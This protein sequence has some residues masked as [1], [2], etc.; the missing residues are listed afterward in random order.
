VGR[1]EFGRHL[2]GEEHGD[3]QQ[4]GGRGGQETA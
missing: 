3:T 2:F 4:L 1:T